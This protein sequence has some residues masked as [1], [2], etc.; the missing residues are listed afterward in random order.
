MSDVPQLGKLVTETG[1]RRDCVHVA[2]VPVTAAC[3]LAPGQRGGFVKEGNT[4][5]VGTAR[6]DKPVEPLGIVDPFLTEE[7]RPGERFYLF[8]FPGTITGMRHV[9]S[10]PSFVAKPP[11]A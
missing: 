11:G 10:H 6:Q 8:L 9:W 2:I 4:D 3:P 1:A 5:L 7:V